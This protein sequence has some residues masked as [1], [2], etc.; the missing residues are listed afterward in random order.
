MVGVQK[1]HGADHRILPD[2]I[3]IGSF[4]GI[5]AMVGDGITIKN[6]S[7]RDLGLIPDAFRRLGVT[8]EERDDDLYIPG[9]QHYQIES[10][11]DGSFMTLAD[12]PCRGSPPTSFRFCSSWPRRPR[13]ACFPPKDV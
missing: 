4:I 1:L 7:R 3:E 10:F 8:V 9:P 2:M 6:V 12:A 13:A 11:I 5:G